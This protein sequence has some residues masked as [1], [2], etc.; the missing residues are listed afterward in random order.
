MDREDFEDRSRFAAICRDF[1]HRA[2]AEGRS[3]RRESSENAD[4][5]DRAFEESLWVLAQKNIEIVFRYSDSPIQTIFLNALALTFIAHSSFLV[6]RPPMQN[7]PEEI[8]SFREYLRGLD[9]FAAWYDSQNGDWTQIDAYFDGEV[10]S[11]RLDPEERSWISLLLFTYHLLPLRGAF[12]VTMEAGFPHVKVNNKGIR[13]DSL[14]WVPSAPEISLVAEFDGFAFHSSKDSF[15]AD[16]KRDRALNAGGVQV[17]R[18][19]G[20]EIVKDPLLAAKDVFEWLQSKAP[21]LLFQFGPSCENRLNPG[22]AY[23]APGIR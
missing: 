14:F 7:A 16:R 19:A 13:V 4:I 8:E 18:F 21:G 22:A 17:Y 3:D 23:A 5:A 20:T 1:V 12:H 2:V 11:G 6:F 9:R 15:I 10:S